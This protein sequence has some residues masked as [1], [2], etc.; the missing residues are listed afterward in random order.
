[1]KKILL[2][3]LLLMLVFLI[4]V[5]GITLVGM[6]PIMAFSEPLERLINDLSDAITI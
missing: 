4:F 3:I 2:G 6:L 1:M 5:F